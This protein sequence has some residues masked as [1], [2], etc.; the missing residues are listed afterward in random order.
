M[1]T[2]DSKGNRR[3]SVAFAVQACSDFD[4]RDQLLQSHL[5]PQCHQLHYLQ[6][7]ME[8]T[9]KAHLIEGGS[10]PMVIQA[11][12]AYIAKVIPII[13]REALARVPGGSSQWIVAAVRTLARRIELLHPQVDNAGTAPANCEY[14]WLDATGQVLVPAQY[15]FTLNLHAAKAAITMIKEVRARAIELTTT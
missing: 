1:R 8:K 5:L 2:T 14:P 9:A 13:V 10:D 11:S 4:A 3:W 7:A 15:D 6:M 12:H